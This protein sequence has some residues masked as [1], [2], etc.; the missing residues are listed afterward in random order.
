MIVRK[1][2]I[3]AGNEPVAVYIQ[4]DSNTLYVLHTNFNGSIEKISDKNGNVVDS[5]SYT[6]FGQRRLFSDWSKTDTSTHLID[7]G[8]T[9]QQHLDNFALINFNGR[10]YDPVLAHFLSPDPYIQAPE[11]PLN[12]NRYSYCLFS[13]LQ[14]VDPTGLMIWHPDK[15]GN[16]VADPGDDYN[17][18]KTYLITI[19]G[20]EN[21]IPASEWDYFKSQIDNY[22]LSTGG[23]DLTGMQLSSEMGTFENLVGKF[24][25]TKCSQD[26][27]WGEGP[28]SINN[29]TPTS[30]RRVNL[31]TQYVYN[32]NILGQESM[33]NPIYKSWQG[34]DVGYST[35]AT[36]V[37]ASLG[38][39]HLVSEKDIL[40]GRLNA[41]S[42]VRL[43]TKEA[44]HSAIFLN[45]IYNDIGNIIG[46][47][48]WQ[49]NINNEYIKST[50]FNQYDSYKPKLGTNFR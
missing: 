25:V 10:M 15:N 49:Q 3:Y 7:R 33:S 23:T 1:Q 22:L 21:K 11:N 41:G 45:Y 46:M 35:F 42:L 32:E 30:F 17:T 36:G 2:N 18:L 8:F 50:Y 9:G 39:G 12:H 48:F 37:I 47:T 20:D 31:A 16:L 6:P 4:N 14:Y 44:W 24:L 43:T 19:Y 28:Y 27:S 29:C 40:N 5:M 26:E 13:P 34:Y 38:L